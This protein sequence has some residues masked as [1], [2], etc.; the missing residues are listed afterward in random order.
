MRDA[1][2]I[3]KKELKAYLVSPIPYVFL[4][5]F[6]FFMSYMFFWHGEGQFFV[7]GKATLE[8]G[9]FDLIP[10]VLVFLVPAI[11]FV[12]LR[13]LI[14]PD[15][16]DDLLAEV[17]EMIA[18]R[19][20]HIDDQPY[21]FTVGAWGVLFPLLLL[22]PAR[23]PGLIRRHPE[24]ADLKHLDVFGNPFEAVAAVV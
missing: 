18:F 12:A 4:I 19:L 14:I 16:P 9:F 21:L 6:T 2:T 15:H 10:W 3:Y 5:I 24:D 11:I 13:I 20:R 22:F 1:V 17:R 7:R 8:M 23:L